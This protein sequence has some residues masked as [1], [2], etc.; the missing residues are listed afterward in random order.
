MRLEDDLP[1]RQ[2]V[3]FYCIFSFELLKSNYNCNLY[4]LTF[5]YS[6]YHSRFIVFY[7]KRKGTDSVGRIILNQFYCE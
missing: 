6:I 7:E 3:V 5:I 1:F 2:R 4:I